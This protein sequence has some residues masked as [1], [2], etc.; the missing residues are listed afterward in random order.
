MAV[1]RCF[2]LYHKPYNTTRKLRSPDGYKNTAMKAVDKDKFAEEGMTHTLKFMV[3]NDGPIILVME[4][5][6]LKT[7]RASQGITMQTDIFWSEKE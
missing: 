4:S 3:M 2:Q 6:A 1:G 7:V 5:L